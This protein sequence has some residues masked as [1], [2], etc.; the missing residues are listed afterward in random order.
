MSEGASV[1]DPIA[2]APG[3][4]AGRRRAWL[5]R[6]SVLLAI[7]LAATFGA[8]APAQAASTTYYNGFEN[9][10]AAWQYINWGHYIGRTTNSAYVRS[11]SYGVQMMTHPSQGTP[12]GELRLNLSMPA[13]PT[14]C[15][16]RIY[17]KVNSVHNLKVSFRITTQGGSPITSVTETYTANNSWHEMYVSSTS[18]P[19]HFQVQ[20]YGFP[21][22]AAGFDAPWANLAV[23]DLTVSCVH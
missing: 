11:G 12:L 9:G 3:P 13:T 5:G 21:P 18:F 16:A 10:E 8:A 19:R 2:P 7:A 6:I 4:Q 23:D 1:A 14:I 17:V 20:V 15:A 22:P